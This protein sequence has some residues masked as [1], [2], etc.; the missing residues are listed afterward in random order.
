MYFRKSQIINTLI[1]YNQYQLPNGLTVIHH[2]DDSTQLC[3]LNMLYNV[4]S[5]HEN[6]TKTGFAHLF[7]HLMFG[8]SIN[9]E[10]FDT[11][12]QDAGGESNA[13]TSN[14][15]TNY[16]LTLPANNIETGFWLESDR[17]LSLDFNQESL[18]IQRNVVIEEFKER[19]LN[20]PY[21]DVWL[22]ILPLAY[23]VHPYS[24]PT[25]GKEISHIEN[26][27]LDDVKDFFKNFYCPNNAV[28]VIAG[29][30]SFEY[31]KTLVTKW[32]ESIPSQNFV[33]INYLQEPIQTEARFET[34]HAD[35]PAN[36]IVKAYHMPARTDL[37]Y[38]AADMLTDLFGSGKSSRFYT[39]LVKS[40]NL[41][42]ELDA[43]ITG[44]VDAGLLI[45]EGKIS[46]G[47]R[48]ED[49]ENSILEI[50]SKFKKDGI[51]DDE[52]N[53]IK[54]KSETNILFNDISALNKAMKLAYAWVLGDVDLV[55]K[56]AELYLK[57]SK[58]DI[59]DA[60]NEIMIPSNCSTL[61]YLSKNV[62]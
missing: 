48:V 13:F 29:N 25:I 33:P 49:A 2:F 4:G 17:M 61:Y 42:S 41:F 37:K 57:V 27:S 9:I 43:Y 46:E 21:G 36:M 3:V 30:I 11:E 20:Q 38:Y 28:L 51:S 22:K 8:G 35:V 10:D 53:K 45:I 40:K 58:Q 34:I 56:E 32:F 15:I 62:K 44:D 59:I 31:T 55:N 1:N 16:Y 24:W 47:V 60:A 50:I 5:K 14:D 12:L 52:L 39:E 23:K 19:Y 18:D 7:E 54:N 26:A 6:P